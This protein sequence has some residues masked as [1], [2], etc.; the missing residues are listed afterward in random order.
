MTALRFILALPFRLCAIVFA[1]LG[2]ALV[3]FSLGLTL[4]AEVVSE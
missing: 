3:A 1:A 2:V 4:M